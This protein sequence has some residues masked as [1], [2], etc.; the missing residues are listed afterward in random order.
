MFLLWLLRADYLEVVDS[1]D[2]ESDNPLMDAGMDS[3]SGRTTVLYM[4]VAKVS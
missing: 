1:L 2:L 3:L 4:T